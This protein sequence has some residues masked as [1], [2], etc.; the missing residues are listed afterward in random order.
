MNVTEMSKNNLK[1]SRFLTGY[2]IV[3]QNLRKLRT[4]AYANLQFDIIYVHYTTTVL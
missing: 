3:W 1:F 4:C 2:W